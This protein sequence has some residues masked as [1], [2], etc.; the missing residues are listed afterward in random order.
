MDSGTD[1]FIGVKIALLCGDKVLVYLRDNKPGINFPGLWDLPGG[2][3]EDH[4]TPEECIT[5]ELQEECQFTLQPEQ[6]VFK[7]FLP[8][9][10]DD[11]LTSCF[12]VADVS[13][14]DIAGMHFGEEGSKWQL[15]PVQDYL[16][17]DDGVKPLQERFQK[18]TDGT[19]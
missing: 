4:E 9:L 18:Y 13:E 5:R 6:I 14:E 17:R 2:G 3:R 7:K 11:S 12:M 1:N 16:Q 10:H 8:A 15:M 19:L